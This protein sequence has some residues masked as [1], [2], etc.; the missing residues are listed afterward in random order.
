MKSPKDTDPTDLFPAVLEAH[1]QRKTPSEET[2]RPKGAGG[3]S[4]GEKLAEEIRRVQS[5]QSLQ[6]RLKA[7][8]RAV[9]AGL[10]ELVEG[11]TSTLRIS[12]HLAL[13]EADKLHFTVLAADGQ[14]L[15]PTVTAYYQRLLKDAKVGYST[16]QVSNLLQV[17]RLGLQIL[18]QPGLQLPTGADSLRKLCSVDNPLAAYKKLHDEHHGAPPLRAIKKLVLEQKRQTAALT[19]GAPTEPKGVWARVHR[20]SQEGIASLQAGNTKEALATLQ[21]LQRF[22]LRHQQSKEPKQ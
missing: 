15:Y 19:E 2:A 6:D 10:P 7:C 12:L 3:K 16:T 22:A 18:S 1:A 11:P 17:G 4:A 21:K 14:P 5:I 9:Q 13:A 8:D 20:W